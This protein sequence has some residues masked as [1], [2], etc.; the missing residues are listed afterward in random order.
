MFVSIFL[1]LLEHFGVDPLFF[2]ILI[3]INLQTSCLTPPM[4]MSAYYL[5]GIAPKEGEL[6]TI[7]KGCF[8]FLGMVFSTIALIYVEPRIVNWLPDLM[9]NSDHSM[10]DVAPGEDNEEGSVID[11]AFL[12]GGSN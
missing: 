1:P 5:K 9:Y 2:G 8:P 12:M 4:A 6:W 7:F 3:A 10:E 11:P